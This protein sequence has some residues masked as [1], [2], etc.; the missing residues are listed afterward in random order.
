[1]KPGRNGENASRKGAKL[2]KKDRIIFFKKQ[3]AKVFLASFAG[4]ARNVFSF[5]F[6][7][8]VCPG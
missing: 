2:A 5:K 8:P 3:D 7:I 1:M 6:L 4:F